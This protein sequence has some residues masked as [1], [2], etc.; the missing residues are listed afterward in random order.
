M[1]IQLAPYVDVINK[2][3]SDID[4]RFALSDD[5]DMDDPQTFYAGVGRRIRAE[6]E[7]RGLTQE[8]LAG[9]VHLTRTSVT[10][11]EKGRQKLLLHTLI[12]FSEFLNVPAAALLPSIRASKIEDLLKG[13]TKKEREFVSNVIDSLE[14][15]TRP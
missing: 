12:D 13:R 3:V 8:A 9:G 15:P 10:N 2:N 1:S 7:R 6:R 11:I 14:P 5:T 4:V